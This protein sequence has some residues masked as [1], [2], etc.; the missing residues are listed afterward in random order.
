LEYLRQDPAGYFGSYLPL[1][2]YTL[3]VGSALN[4][5]LDERPVQL[6]PELLLLDLLYVLALLLVP[7]ARTSRAGLL[8]AFIGLHFLTMLVFAPY[9][10]ENRLVTPMYLFVGVFGA[11]ALANIGARTAR[12]IGLRRQPTD[13][14][15][16]QSAQATQRREATQGI[17]A[18]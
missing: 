12:R 17:V 11:A 10:Y 13:G 16:P 3:G 4:D 8:H 15:P 5:L 2:A 7:A 9:D 14:S 1:A 18:K 6:Q